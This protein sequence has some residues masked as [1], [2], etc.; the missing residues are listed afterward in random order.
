[1]KMVFVALAV[2]VAMPVG[3]QV[4][5]PVQ[6]E[7]ATPVI[8]PAKLSQALV[9]AKLWRNEAL[10]QLLL[11]HTYENVIPKL[12]AE[13]PYMQ[14]LEQRYPGSVKVLVDSERAALTRMMLQNIPRW[15]RDDAKT[16]AEAMTDEEIT[17]TIRF[18]QTT[19]GQKLLKI[20]SS[21]ADNSEWVKRNLGGADIGR[22]VQA[23]DL[24]TAAQPVAK[25]LLEALSP[26]EFV[27]L[28]EFMSTSAGQKMQDLR[29][30]METR[31]AAENVKG[32]PAQQA[33]EAEVRKA[34][35]SHIASFEK[36]KAPAK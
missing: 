26:A 4:Q 14:S 25:P 30:K 1:M 24:Q 21:H 18:L 27:V 6:A 22:A 16:I 32:S 5:T 31:I 33:M 28:N 34:F 12:M 11:D 3:A 29:A 8:N 20:A 13:Q 35:L 17:Q 36:K 2:S 9:L 15:Q 10:T 19:S 23:K 7:V